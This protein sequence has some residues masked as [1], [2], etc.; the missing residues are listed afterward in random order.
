MISIYQVYRILNNGGSFGNDVHYEL[1]PFW[2]NDPQNGR[3]P[4]VPS[5]DT[6]DEAVDFV[7]TLK[8]KSGPFTII[9]SWTASRPY[10]HT[11]PH[12]PLDWF[13]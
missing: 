9:E 10:Q 5:F 1:M 3:Y 11:R 12:I 13:H 2:V 4:W 7:K 6:K 8:G